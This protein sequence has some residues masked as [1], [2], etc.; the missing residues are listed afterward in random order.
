LSIGDLLF[1]V[2][3]QAAKV[4]LTSIEFSYSVIRRTF[5]LTR[6]EVLPEVFR[7]KK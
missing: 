4:L 6:K 7:K 2:P 1:S 5:S 3:S